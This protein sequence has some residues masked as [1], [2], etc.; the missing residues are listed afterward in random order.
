MK[1]CLLAVL[2]LL[3]ITL[4][5]TVAVLAFR[6]PGM[7]KVLVI[8]A[9]GESSPNHP[10]KPVPAKPPGEP[11][12]Y[13]QYWDADKAFAVDELFAVTSK[14]TIRREFYT[15]HFDRNPFGNPTTKFHQPVYIVRAMGRETRENYLFVVT[16][17]FYDAAD[18]YEKFTKAELSN[19]EYFL[20][21]EKLQ[22]EIFH[23][24]FRGR[25]ID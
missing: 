17:E 13:N 18:I 25:M 10:E 22:R 14:N 20:S 11:K 6:N 7:Q 5:V 9:P 8:F 15:D 24:R 16:R 3:V 21:E 4:V 12:V 19:Y 23:R 1:S 2:F